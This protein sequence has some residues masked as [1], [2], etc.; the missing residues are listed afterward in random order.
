MGN[1]P[2]TLK[3]SPGKYTIAVSAAGYKEWNRE[4]TVNSG[5]EIKLSANLEKK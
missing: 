1:T 2:S 4:L 3:L 5:S